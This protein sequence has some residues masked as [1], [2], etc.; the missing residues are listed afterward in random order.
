M[1]HTRKFLST[2]L[3]GLMLVSSSLTLAQTTSNVQSSNTYFGVSA[4]AHYVIPSLDFHLG[5][6]DAL[7]E[8]LDLR[9]TLSSFLVEGSGFIIGS[10]NGITNLNTGNGNVNTYVGFGPRA[11][12]LIGDAG[13]SQNAIALAVG[14]L[15][16]TEFNAQG[17]TRPF[18]EIDGTI[19]LTVG[20]EVFPGF[21]PIITLSAGINFHF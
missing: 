11:A 7:G 6:K 8:N 2:I 15:W 16:G 19:P 18:V 21:F 1:K 3:L 13:A 4:S 5:V 9:G 12:L 10:L 20:S 17:P 14:G